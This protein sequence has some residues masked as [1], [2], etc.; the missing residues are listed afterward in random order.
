[1]RG[2]FHTKTGRKKR[3]QRD[4]RIRGGSKLDMRI[5]VAVATELIK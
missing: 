4:V 2:I 3:R 5:T 1:L